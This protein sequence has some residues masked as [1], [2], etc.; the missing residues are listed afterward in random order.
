MI[1][2]IG[3]LLKDWLVE[4]KSEWKHVGRINW[5]SEAGNGEATSEYGFLIHPLSQNFEEI[6][7]VSDMHVSSPFYMRP[8]MIADPEFFEKL[9]VAMDKMADEFRQH[10]NRNTG[11]E[12]FGSG[13]T[14]WKNK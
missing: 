12:S 8:V 6:L 4:E 10:P 9:K 5:E 2:G 3:D 7:W 14:S 13:L 11:H 1:P